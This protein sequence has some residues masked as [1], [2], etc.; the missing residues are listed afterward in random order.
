MATFPAR[1]KFLS[2]NEIIFLSG[3]FYDSFDFELDHAFWTVWHVRICKINFGVLQHLARRSSAAGI[4]FCKL[5]RMLPPRITPY[6]LAIVIC[7][8]IRQ[9]RRR[10]A[11]EY[12]R[13]STLSL[14]E[15]RPHS[16][17]WGHYAETAC[18]RACKLLL[19][20]WFRRYR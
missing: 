10:S 19:R 18:S 5:R 2:R 11:L 16:S 3:T 4:R 15:R 6:R 17:A 1:V 14:G 13:C 9:V 20:R 12:C 8:R 7:A